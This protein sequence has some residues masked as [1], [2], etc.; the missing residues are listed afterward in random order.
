MVSQFLA[1]DL[2]STDVIQSAMETLL[3]Y[4]GLTLFNDLKT[5]KSRRQIIFIYEAGERKL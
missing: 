1:K 2:A 4:L 3:H 5:I